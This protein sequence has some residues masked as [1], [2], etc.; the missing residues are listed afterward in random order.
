MYLVTKLAHH[1]TLTTKLLSVHTLSLHSNSTHPMYFTSLLAHLHAHFTLT[2]LCTTPPIQT[3]NPHT[4]FLVGLLH[5]V[6]CL[7]LVLLFESLR[8][9]ISLCQVTFALLL[10][11][12]G[13]MPAYEQSSYSNGN[14]SKLSSLVFTIKYHQLLSY[15]FL[16]L[17]SKVTAPHAHGRLV[18]QVYRCA[19]AEGE[20][21]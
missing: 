1:K 16:Y 9:S 19:L 10:C 17:M 12:A 13:T 4:Y 14:I 20:K 2:T 5:D 18:L 3:T 7:S 21:W 11:P 8:E 6:S 15:L